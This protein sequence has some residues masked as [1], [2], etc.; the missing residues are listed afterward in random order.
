MSNEQQSYVQ[1]DEIETYQT[2]PFSGSSITTSSLN[3]PPILNA[4]SADSAPLNV[5]RP[6]SRQIRNTHSAPE[7]EPE[8]S[9]IRQALRAIISKY[10]RTPIQCT[11]VL[12]QIYSL[13]IDGS[14]TLNE[15]IEK[16]PAISRPSMEERMSML[17]ELQDGG[18]INISKVGRSIIIKSGPVFLQ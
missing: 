17:Q 8:D 12:N 18:L 5:P 2:P 16:T 7:N 1:V 4:P 15:V 11:K 10:F 6:R 13:G 9:P 3:V 14:V